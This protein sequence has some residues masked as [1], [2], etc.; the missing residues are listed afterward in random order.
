MEPTEIIT[1]LA[2]QYSTTKDKVRKC[3]KLLEKKFN[4]VPKDEVLLALQGLIPSA[5]D[6]TYPPLPISPE[7]PIR[8]KRIVKVGK[9]VPS[10][11]TEIGECFS[12]Y[13]PL[14]ETNAFPPY[15]CIAA[16]DP[17]EQA[18]PLT[19]AP[20]KRESRYVVVCPSCEHKV[21]VH[22]LEGYYTSNKVRP[23]CING[24]CNTE[25]DVS[26]LRKYLPVSY[27]PIFRKILKTAIYEEELSQLPLTEAS[28]AVS[29]YSTLGETRITISGE[30]AARAKNVD[31]KIK[32]KKLPLKCLIDGCPGLIDESSWKCEK[33]GKKK[34]E[35]CKEYKADKHVCDPY[36]LSLIAEERKSGCTCPGCG[37]IWQKTAGCD[38]MWCIS[39]HAHYNYVKGGVG[40]PIPKGEQTNGAWREY[41][42]MKT[43][44]KASKTGTSTVQNLVLDAGECPQDNVFPNYDNIMR[45][46]Y[47]LFDGFDK[48]V[49]HLLAGI[50][51]LSTSND[52]GFPVAGYQRVLQEE[53]ISMEREFIVLA[54]DQVK[55]N[56]DA[57]MPRIH[58][59]HGHLEQTRKLD[60]F[61]GYIG[62]TIPTNILDV[63]SRTYKVEECNKL[64]RE[65]AFR[66][67]KKQLYARRY[68]DIANMFRASAIIIFRNIMQIIQ[69]IPD[70]I[71]ENRQRYA[72]AVYEWRVKKGITDYYAFP[73]ELE[74][75]EMLKD[76]FW[77]ETDG[78]FKYPSNINLVNRKEMQD[79]VITEL[80]S[81]VDLIKQTNTF[82][83]DFCEAHAEPK[84][85]FI[86][87]N[88]EF[89]IPSHAHAATNNVTI[90]ETRHGL[91]LNGKRF[92]KILD[93]EKWDVPNYTKPKAEHR[94]DILDAIVSKKFVSVKI[95]VNINSVANDHTYTLSPTT[96][97]INVNNV[98][99]FIAKIF[100]S[101]EK[102]AHKLKGTLFVSWRSQDNEE[103]MQR[104]IDMISQLIQTS[105]FDAIHLS[106]RG[107]N[108]NAHHAIHSVDLTNL[109]R[110]I[111]MRQFKKISI[112]LPSL[113]DE[114]CMWMLKEIAAKNPVATKGSS[115]KI[116]IDFDR[117]IRIGHN[118]YLFSNNI[119]NEVVKVLGYD[120]KD[121]RQYLV[122]GESTLYDQ[123]I[124]PASTTRIT[125]K[126]GTKR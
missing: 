116:D 56:I 8:R 68:L 115:L 85:P 3:I 24:T 108:A 57:V 123:S 84:H 88:L 38:H 104:K 55:I 75:R 25:F 93:I 23:R 96:I 94:S 47:V 74:K 37:A 60:T 105:Q 10:T 126:M 7:K 18:D 58:D 15:V 79:A 99:D 122:V 113:T 19:L 35:K 117:F 32:L 97:N 48:E 51:R 9:N 20:S 26:V 13:N 65:R 39:C 81:L 86:M 100:E 50:H 21:C 63:N 118:S 49:Y 6:G 27:L 92:V 98:F 90:D 12:C 80:G 71:E 78:N 110:S 62:T 111:T 121:K 61:K 59:V 5:S 103:V 102:V 34:C 89:Y 22:D 120:Y 77:L 54:R 30:L 82:F 101:L 2:H 14:F 70:I 36:I 1:R 53:S 67:Y 106:L 87:H 43:A 107:Y 16:K 31:N 45:D 114:T 69:P 46:L 17:K 73:T 119:R 109:T 124:Y 52:Y 125:F 41:Q 95:N 42:R 11:F 64:F 4:T 29:G 66:F 91:Y 72:E 83:K 28:V 33:C 112:W 40:K 44:L 76:G